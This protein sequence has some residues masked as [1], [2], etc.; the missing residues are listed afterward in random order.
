M[1]VRYETSSYRLS[2]WRAFLLEYL[3]Y[4]VWVEKEPNSLRGCIRRV[5]MTISEQ[6][7]D[8]ERTT[9]HARIKSLCH[10]A[11]GNK[12]YRQFGHN[13][14][15]VSISP[16]PKYHNIKLGKDL[17]VAAVYLGDRSYIEKLI[18][19]GSRCGNCHGNCPS[20]WQKMAHVTSN[21]FGD[22]YGAATFKGDLSMLRL[23][24]SSSPDFQQSAPLNSSL[25]QRTLRRAAVLGHKDIFDFALDSKPID[26][27][28]GERED[29]RG[30]PEYE[31]LRDAIASTPIVENYKRGASMF[32]PKSKIFDP[33]GRGSTQARLTEKADA[34]HVDMVRYFLNQ[35]ILLSHNTL[36]NGVNGCEPLLAGVRGGNL[37]VVK[38]LLDYGADPNCFPVVDTALMS[39]VRLSRLSIAKMLLEAGARSNEGCPPPIVLAVF[40]EDMPMFRLL[41]QYGA[42]LDTP[43]A[44]NWAMAVAQFYELESMVDVLV[45]EGVEKGA[46]LHRCAGRKEIYQPQYLF[47]QCA[48]DQEDIWQLAIEQ[49][50]LEYL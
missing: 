28:A 3:A 43:E 14:F 32:I 4:Q 34:G 20:S 13:L 19:Q 48:L 1:D 49:D 31:C 33:R 45:Q 35:G 39:A 30:Y 47:P 11:L 6:V 10:L 41:R 5:A 22:A 46:V 42:T 8:T 16:I 15:N 17:F 9:I 21:V 18:S 24:I 29:C 50:A 44:G 12:E 38:L 23:L 7:G 27:T 37:D 2:D 40:K 36:K 25:H 26:L